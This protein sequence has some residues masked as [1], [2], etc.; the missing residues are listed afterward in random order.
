MSLF[1]VSPI[2]DAE[3]GTWNSDLE[4]RAPGSGR[5]RNL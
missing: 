5:D 2:A 3:I 4:N 1:L